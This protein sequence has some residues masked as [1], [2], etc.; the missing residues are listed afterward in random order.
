MAAGPVVKYNG[1]ESELMEDAERQWDDAT[2]G[3]LMFI[4]ADNTYTFDATDV[5]AS[6]L[7]G[8]ITAGDGA[9]IN[10]A[11]PVIDKT[12]LPGSTF[13]Q[14]ADANFGASVTITAKFLICVKPVVA[15]TFDGASD[16]LLWCADLDTTSS[17]TSKSSTASDFSLTQPVNGWIKST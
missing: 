10:L 11:S 1:L 17:S 9:P 6:D 15:G 13:L 12:T 2:A 4:L 5:L 3:S 7:L 16:K 14:S 8:V